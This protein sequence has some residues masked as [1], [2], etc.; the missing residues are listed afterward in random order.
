MATFVIR[1]TVTNNGNIPAG[2]WV[3]GI[4]ETPY[5]STNKTQ[6]KL[7]TIDPGKSAS[8]ELSA[9]GIALKEGTYKIKVR[10]LKTDTRE[11]LAEDEVTKKF[12]YKISVKITKVTVK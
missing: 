2:V 3:V 1:G 10:V 4:I 9:S 12:E 6:Y 11:V 7:M 5:G 8:F